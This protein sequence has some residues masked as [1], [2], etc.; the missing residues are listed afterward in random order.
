VCWQ[1]AAHLEPSAAPSAI[2]GALDVLAKISEDVPDRMV[3]DKDQ[4]LNAILPKVFALLTAEPEKWRAYSLEI[5]NRFIMLDPPVMQQNMP[6]LLQA[7][8]HLTQD[9]SAPVRKQVI[10]GINQLVDYRFSDVLPHM[11]GVIEFML[12]SMQDAD[13]SVA[14][15]AAAFWSAIAERGA[16]MEEQRAAREAIAPYLARLVPVLLTA[17]VY[18]EDDASM[19]FADDDDAHIPDKEEDIAPA[20]TR[21]GDV[22]DEDEDEGEDSDGGEGSWNLRKG[23]AAALDLMSYVFQDEML[24]VLLPLIEQL[25]QNPDWQ[26]RESAILA[27]GAVRTH[28]PTCMPACLPACLLAGLSAEDFVHNSGLFLLSLCPI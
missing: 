12:H 7:I 11:S 27:I 24:A 13:G 2:E 21:R 16:S 25:L 20:Q 15:E 3:A 6:A 4:P 26:R 28:S 1:L 19:E 5:I 18:D 17:M 8:F 23:S 14:L 9:P 10:I 22:E